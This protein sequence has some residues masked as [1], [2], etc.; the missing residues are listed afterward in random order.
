MDELS[1]LLY[2]HPLE[3]VAITESWLTIE[4]IVSYVV[5]IDGHDTF[6]KVW[7]HGRGGGVCVHL[8]QQVFHV[9]VDKTSRLQR[10]VL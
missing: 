6:R 1:L 2:M 9:N 5:L 4:I 10:L 8:F 7:V 3:V